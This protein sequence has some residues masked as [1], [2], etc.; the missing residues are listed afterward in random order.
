MKTITVFGRCRFIALALLA[1][2]TLNA[3]LSTARA[4]GT[5]FTYQ[6]QLYAAGNPANGVYDL[7]LLLF[8]ALTGGSQVGGTQTNLG[9]GV[10]N[11]L[12]TLTVDFGPVFTGSS[13]W[14]R[15]DVRTNGA[16]SF[17]QLAPRQP[18]TPAPYAIFADTAGN[19]SGVVASANLS[20]T[21]GNALTLNN[22]GNSFTGNGAGLTSLNASQLTGGTMPDARL[23]GN[24]A[25]LDGNQ[26]FTGSN[27]FSG[28]NSSLS[29]SGTGPISTSIFTGLGFQFYNSSGEG[30][31]MSSVND[32]NASLTFYTKQG[33]GFPPAKQMKIDRYGVVMIDQQN[34]NYGA[35]NDGTTNG[36]GL[37][38]GGNSGEG[39]A[40]Q[41]TPGVNQFGL[42]FYTDH[43]R[44]MSILHNG[45]VGMGTTNPATALQVIGTVTATAFSGNGSGL[46]N[47]NASQLTGGTVPL[48]QLPD[49]VALL[50]DT[51]SANFFAGLLAGNV[52]LSGYRN[53]G[54]GDGALGADRAGFENTANG[55]DALNSDKAGADNTASGAFALGDT[56]SGSENTAMG[57]GALGGNS[58]GS[59]NVAIGYEAIQDNSTDSGLVAV[60]FQALQNDSAGHG[61]LT[62]GGASTAIGYQA[63]QG[64]TSGADNTGVGYQSLMMNSAG[65]DN[66]GV[67]IWS[68]IGCTGSEN[69]AIGS[70][71]GFS[72]TTGDN[73]IDIGNPGA[74]GDNGVI[75][76]GVP[77]TQASAYLAGQVA[78]NAGLNIDQTGTYG[79]NGGAVTS[80]ALTFGTGPSGSGEG[81]A[82][83]RTSG[84]NQFDLT[85][86]TAFNPRMTI[87]SGGNVGIGTTSPQSA[88]DVAGTTRTQVLTITGGSDLAEPFKISTADQPVSEGDVVVIDEANPGQLKLTDQPYDTRVAGVI[89]GANGVHPGIQMQQL[90]LLE[91]G[92]NVALTGRV[93]VQADASNGPI[94][95]GDLLTTSSSPG[96]AMKVSDHVKA[97]GAILGKAMTGLKEGHGMVLVLVTLQ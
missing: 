91:G 63:L 73:N 62:I 32:A 48:A 90:G 13:N 57:A 93:Y 87:L 97:Q 69:I 24:V 47:L 58:T 19:V 54:V 81:I 14:M 36:A 28:L 55:Y 31:I 71:A 83:Q 23:S 68:L 20:G 41:R 86:Y 6:G 59:N 2:V 67:G 89:S 9:V 35:V 92:K 75:R 52:S 51:G 80:N 4:Q 74:S 11:G 3:Q 85:L 64:N 43:V 65:N 25:L 18:L 46:T 95:P 49:T 7:R 45:N 72:L 8:N 66:T 27:T 39:I 88:L 44:Q 76:I 84:P 38:F 12:F 26:S 61:F 5:A 22:A 79:L 70:L 78:I 77:G 50:S 60:G 1:F 33:P 21:Y 37:T 34:A 56:T 94:K 15:I 29:I 16:N 40:S 10:T 17:T 30:A 42:D 82:S 96:R 53:T